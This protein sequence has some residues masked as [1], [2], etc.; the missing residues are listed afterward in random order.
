MPQTQG[1]ELPRMRLDATAGA[2]TVPDKSNRGAASMLRTL[3]VGLSL[4]AF[5]PAAQA[6]EPKPIEVLLAQDTSYVSSIPKPEDVTGYMA[7]EIIFTPDLHRDYIA[8]VDAASDRVSVATIGRSHFGRPILRVTITS[9][10]N[11]ARLEEIRQTQLSLANEG[12]GEAPADHPVVI[13]LTHGVH[14]SEPSGYDSSKLI[15]YHLAAGQGA[16][17]ERMLEETVVH[18]VV[19]I[20]PDG[21]NRFGQWTNLH[22]AQ[23]PVADPQHREH[24]YEWPWGRTNHYWF[25]INRQWVPVTQPEAVA[26]VNATH[27]WLPNIA[28]DLHEMG[29]N[30]TYFFS[31]GPTDGLHPLLSQDALQLNLDMNE[32]I[33]EQLDG[34]GAVYVTEEVFDDFYLGYGSSYPGLIGSVPYLF[35]QSSTRGIIQESEFGIKRYDD[36]VGQQARVAL[37][38]IRS[39]QARRADLQAH[40][41][42]FFNE[43]REMASDSPVSG[44]LISSNDHGRMADFL[45]ML[46]VHRIEVRGL[47]QDVRQG[48]RTYQA[49]EA[50]YIPTR[51]NTYRV[52]EGLFETRII[53]DK[54][55]FYDVSGWTQ[56]LAW[57]IDYTPVRGRGVSSNALGDAVV[58]FDRSAPAPD[59]TPY[60]YVMEWDSY[61]APRALY[62]L[63]D[64]GVRARVI[65]DE[66][67]I[68]TTRGPVDPG[69]GAIMVQ[70]AGQEATADEIHAMMAR[71]ASEDSV[72]VHAVTSGI[73]SRGS[74]IGG[75]A[76]SNVERPEVLLVTGRGI[77]MNDAGELWHLLDFQQEMPVSM[78]DVNELGRADLDRYTHIIMPNGRYSDLGES[79]TEGLTDWVRGG[80]VLIGIRGG[81]R[82]A[83]S[84]E[85][86]SAEWLEDRDEGDA[87]DARP[88]SNI[89]AWDAEIDI[90]GAVFETEVDLTHP[91]L[92]GLGDSS[93]SVHKIGNQAFQPGDNPFALPVRYVDDDPI[94][95]GYASVENRERLEGQGMLH[96]ERVGRGS[97]IVFADN[98][99]FRA[100][101]RGSARLVTNAMFFGDDFRNPGR[102]GSGPY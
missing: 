71:A 82:W 39:G 24:F 57:D 102:R 29:T 61:Y 99:V 85:L 86:S 23:A 26:L 49:G 81:A 70:V 97:V 90:S 7:G 80:G 72:T 91:L 31:P 74:D 37:S 28:V 92:Y 88:Y 32:T 59:R 95:S 101:Y 17:H 21:A 42:N 63:L 96:A 41:R 46:S 94:Q 8:A 3:A 58:D 78:I 14:G 69:R 87:P 18:L 60:V 73:T 25:D 45:E 15:L 48:G 76:L 53:T 84:A 100:Y 65:P 5:T 43:S 12:A 55:E 22:H 83:I 67:T 47:A 38:L 19:M 16:E 20:N 77:S 79:E 66:T 40:T 34:E 9:E 62:R 6:Y 56:P 1:A 93:L 64:A 35:E 10:A 68:E 2:L 30:S 11:Q 52:I 36:Q 89:N 75:F 13:Q 54:A 4:L 33:A 50:F 27:D 98:P 51:Q 44:Y